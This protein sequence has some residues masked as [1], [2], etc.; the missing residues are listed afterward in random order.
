MKN[1]PINHT[2]TCGLLAFCFIRRKEA[3][4]EERTIMGR[5]RTKRA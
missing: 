5:E 3:R 4:H 2:F 1:K